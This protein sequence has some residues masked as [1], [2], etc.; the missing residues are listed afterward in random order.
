[1]QCAPNI[2][3]A[4]KG[5]KGRR[6]RARQRSF[7]DTAGKA[8]ST[9][10]VDGY[11]TLMHDPRR[12]LETPAAGSTMVLRCMTQSGDSPYDKGRLRESVPAT[13]WAPPASLCRESVRYTRPVRGRRRARSL[14]RVSSLPAPVPPTGVAFFERKEAPALESRLHTETPDMSVK[15]PIPLQPPV[16]GSPALQEALDAVTAY[17]CHP[18]FRSIP[19]APSHRPGAGHGKPAPAS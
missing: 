3:P 11:R 17:A 1:M 5:K 13:W 9:R 2:A 8:V 4:G 14:W 16:T 12:S 18:T 15:P 19:P 10:R 6:C 7:P